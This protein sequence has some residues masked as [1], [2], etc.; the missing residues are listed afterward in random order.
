MTTTRKITMTA[1]FKDF[2]GS[3]DEVTE[4]LSFK[5]HGEE[6]H[7]KH[8]IQGKFLLNLIA[9]SSSTNV[10]T[11]TKVVTDFFNK[12]LIKE[13][14]ERFDELL[15]SD[16]IVTVETLAEITEWL[17]S[18]YTDRPEEQPENSSAGQ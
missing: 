5:L 14:A 11:S 3:Q 17:M 18:Q 2:G 13:S 4:P 1:R 12:V 7:C 6:F 8:A 16:K 10:E 15:S 9:D